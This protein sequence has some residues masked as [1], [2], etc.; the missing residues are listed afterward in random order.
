MNKISTGLCLFFLSWGRP[1]GRREVEEGEG[2]IIYAAEF[3]ERVCRCS[4]AGRARFG[5][6]IGFL[7]GMLLGILR[8]GYLHR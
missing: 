1:G 2:V 3:R 5:A 7:C 8:G 4:F 6:R